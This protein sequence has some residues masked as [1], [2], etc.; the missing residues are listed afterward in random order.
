[1]RNFLA[2]QLIALFAVTAFAQNPA[3]S[4]TPTDQRG[5]GIQ[6]GTTQAG[7]TTQQPREAKPELV[8]QTGYNNFYGATRLVF[9]P[10]GR[11]LAT[12]TF[13]SNTI[14]LWETATGRK[15]RDLSSSGQ[16]A[17][18]IA[19]YVAFSRDSRL[20][21]AASADNAVKVW[22]VMSG[23]EVQTLAGPQGSMYA[24]IGVYFIGFAANNQ[25]VTVS[26][27]ARVW[28][29][30]SGRELRS[31]HSQTTP[32]AAGFNGTDGG[33]VLSPDGAQF[34]VVNDESEAHVKV[35]DVATGRESRRLKLPHDDIES[36]QLAFTSDG[37]LL[38]AG[39]LERRFKLWDLT[40]KK[41]Q[42]LARTAKDYAQVRFSGDGRLLALSENSNIKIWDVTTGRELPALKLPGNSAYPQYDAFMNFSEDGKR[43]AAGGFVTDTTL[44]ETETGK[45]L[46]KLSGRTNM[47]YSVAFSADGTQLYSGDRTRWDLRTGRGLRVASRSS[48]EN[49]YGFPSLDGRLLAVVRPNSNVLSLVEVPS[50][51]EVFTLTPSG[52]AGT[53][54]RVRFSRD[55]TLIAASYNQIEIQQPTVGS[56]GRGSQVKIWDV[57]TGRELRS[58]AANEFPSDAEFSTDGRMIGTVGSM[59]QTS[60]WEVQSGNK[61]DLTSSPMAALTNM[62][63]IKP[64][65]MPTMPNMNDLAAIM[66]NALGTMAAGTMGRSSLA[67]S[68]DGRIVAT[69]GFES[70]A[71]IDIAAMMSGAR[72]GQKPKKGSKQPDSDDIMRDLKVEAIGQVQLWDVASGREIGALKGHS[73]GVVK[74]S[75]SRDGKMLASAGSDNTIRIWDVEARRELRTLVGHT[76]SVES[77]D[78]SPDGSLLASAGD[79]GSTFLWDTRTGEHLLTLISLDDGAEWMAVTPQG[80]FDG[81]PL[82]WNQILWRYNQETFNVAPIEWFFNEFYYPGLLADVFAGKRP[83]VAQDVS[84]KDRRQPVVKLSLDGPA[85][86]TIAS[87]TVKVKIDITDAPADKDNPK[88]SGA[89]DVRLFRNGSLVKVWHGD[90][91]KGQAAAS[92]EQEITVTTGPNR[93]VAY[94]FNRDNVKSKDAPLVFEGAE[95]LK[96]KGTAYI[97]A[98]GVNE[99]ANPQY[100]LKYA[101]A[102][103]KSFGD[104]MRRKQTQIAGFE[105]VEVIELLDANATK[106]N[107][108]SVIKR[109]AGEPGPPTLK[110]GAAD[111]LKRVEP[112]DTVIIYYAGHGTAQQQRFYLIPHDLGYTGDRRRLTEAGLKTMLSHSI[113]DIELQAAVEG[114]DAGHLLLIIDA[115][116]SGQALEA[117]EKRRG[118]MNSKGLAQLAYE[119]GM[120]ILTAAQSFQAA[121]EAAQLGHGYLTYALVEEGL[122]T[123]VADAEPKDGVLIAR[124]WLNFATERVPRMQEEKMAQGRGLGIAFTEGEADVTDP[125][126]RTVQRPRVF[127]RRELEANPL[128]IAKP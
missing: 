45:Q 52:E 64:G 30:T 32:V 69:G 84:K 22:D 50:G 10:D 67:F 106:E 71:N 102:D 126:K 87:R 62:G 98:V 36:L 16:S 105:R 121:L 127:Y 29:V 12:A 76:A 28:D 85:A 91:L 17:P 42:E 122:K 66:T 51:R 53:V 54:Q 111:G 65:Q 4:P 78:F 1:M 100:N 63:N 116:N 68:P 103:A 119:K 90:V 46:A 115:C 86:S 120:Y 49:S 40:S 110:A 2:L 77:I 81:T 83:R 108:L 101:V 113:S 27:T 48:A 125:Q 19:P 72:S 58:L 5:L 79:D 39:L 96:R 35:I 75:F 25:I 94:A 44:W 24:A 112:E 34:A 82:S 47:A 124:E 23:R 9:S 57:K 56:I 33:M 7:Q 92:L 11:L 59:G 73:R 18:G 95:S 70:K 38:A 20:I 118:P 97:I 8:L 80:L 107:I 21:A 89:Q 109:L 104:E 6:S 55:G 117:E 93:L 15:L 26:D 3:P 13:R 43:I 31:L 128:I 61:R 14:K 123:P 99:Y 37:R 60:L 41:E 114:L 74:V 88:G